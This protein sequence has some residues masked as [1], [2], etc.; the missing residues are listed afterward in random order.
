MNVEYEKKYD[1]DIRIES[2]ILRIPKSKV[3][4][5]R[6]LSPIFSISLLFALLLFAAVYD[7]TYLLVVTCIFFVQYCFGH[8]EHNY[9][10][11]HY[12]NVN[13]YISDCFLKMYTYPSG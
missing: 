6:Q 9:T 5:Y 3:I 4:R 10:T 7:T 12:Y 2:K 13:D 11:L 1:H 8:N